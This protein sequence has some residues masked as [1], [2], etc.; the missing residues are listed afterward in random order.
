MLLV[1]VA[2]RDARMEDVLLVWRA[3]FETCS[4][5]KQLRAFDL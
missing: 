5:Q 1:V 2:R 3:T 4:K